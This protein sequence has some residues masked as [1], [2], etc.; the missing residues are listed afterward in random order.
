MTA[1][2]SLLIASVFFFSQEINGLYTKLTSVNGELG[3]P[4]AQEPEARTGLLLL[5]VYG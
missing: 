1:P 4:D 3:P 5:P 2:A